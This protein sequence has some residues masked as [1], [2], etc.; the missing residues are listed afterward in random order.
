MTDS[1]TDDDRDSKNEAQQLLDRL[2]DDPD[3]TL[4]YGLVS[5]ETLAGGQKK[6]AGWFTY[7]TFGSTDQ[8]R[9]SIAFPDEGRVVQ[10]PLDRI[11]TVTLEDPRDE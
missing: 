9:M 7:G 3:E 6:A 4:T 2:T 8:A 10:L 1:D 11:H 5:Y